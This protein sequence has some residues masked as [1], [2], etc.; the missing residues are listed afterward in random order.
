MINKLISITNQLLD[1]GKRNRLLNFKDTGLKTLKL[2]N[3]NTEEIFRG[4][5]NAKEFPVFNADKALMEFHKVNHIEETPINYSEELVYEVCAPLL[6][7]EILCYKKGYSLDKTLKSLCK[8]FKFSLQEKGINSLYLSF[9]FIKY[10]EEDIEFLAPLLLIPIELDNEGEGYTI[11]QYEDEVLLNPT[12]KFYFNATYQIDLVDYKEDALSTYY[13]KIREVLPLDITLEDTISIGIYSFY[14]MN[15]YNDLMQNKQIVIKNKNI[16]ALLGEAKPIKEKIINQATYP[17]VNCDS[18]QLEAI[19]FAVNGKSFCLQGPPGSGKSQTITNIISS[20]LGSGKKVL[21]VSEKIAALNVVYENLRRAN[22]SDFAIELHSNKANKKEFIDNLYQAAIQP[23]YDVDFKTRFLEAKY[24]SLKLNLDEYEKEIHAIIPELKISLLDLY[25]MYMNVSANPI[26]FE[27]HVKDYNF[28]DLEKIIKLLKKYVKLSETIGYDYKESSLYGLNQVSQSYALYHFE[29]DLEKSLKHLEEMIEVKDILNENINLRISTIE[30]CYDALPVLQC[31]LELKTFAPC[32]FDK[33][34]RSKLIN[35]IHAYLEASKSIHTPLFQ[36]YQQTII[37]ED[38]PNLI[39]VLNENNKGIFKNKLFKDAFTK[40]LSY[41]VEKEKVEN[42]IEELQQLA[43]VKKNIF[44]ATTLSGTISKLLGN[45]K[46]LNL[47]LIFLDLKKLNQCQDIEITSL[48]YEKIKSEFHTKTISK[49]I[50]EEA[51][52][53]SSLSNLFNDGFVNIY[54]LPIEEVYKTC[55]HIYE[56]RQKLATFTE[57]NDCIEELKKY[58]VIDYLDFYL[59]SKKDLDTL[60]IDYK[61]LFLKQKIK[62]R[63]KD[64]SVLN[65]F[66]SEKEE[67]IIQRFRELDEKRLNINRDYIISLNSQKRPKDEIIEGTEFKILAREHEK[68]RRQLPIRVLLEE[69]FELALD[70]KPVFLMSPLSVSTYLASKLNMFDCVIFDEASQIFASDALGAIYRAKQCIVIGD[71]KQMPPTNFF[72]AG[73]DDTNEVEYDLESILDKASYTF[74]TTSLKWHYRSRSEELITFSNLSF[75]NSNLIT[76][77]Q[78]KVHTN[79][80][81]IDF[82]Y[83][84]NGR[85]DTNTRTNVIEA[86][87]VCD[88]VFEHMET[89]KQSLGV[90]AFSNVQAELIA[91]LVEKRLKKNPEYQKYFDTFIDEPFFVKNLESVQ[92]DERDRIIFSICY[93]YNEENKFYQRFGPLNNIGGERRLN[94][95]ITRAKYNISVVSSIKYTDIKSTTESQGVLLLRSYL[96]FAENVIMN[97]NYNETDNG[98]IQSVKSYLEELGYSCYTH[99]GSSQFKV[100]LA[101]KK[102][103]TFIMAIMLDGNNKYISNITDKYRLEKLLLERLGWKYYKLFTTAWVNHLEEEKRRLYN[104]LMEENIVIDPSIKKEQSFLKVDNSIDSLDVY[105]E[106]YEELNIEK[107]KDYLKYK[108]FN[109][110]LHEIIRIEQPIHEDYLLKKLS[111][112][113]DKTKTLTALRDK[114]ENELS[115]EVIKKDKFYFYSTLNQI[116]LRISSD[117]EISFVPKEE[118]LH[119][120]YT[121]VSKNNGIKQDGCYKTIAQLLGY[122]KVTPNVRKALDD[123]LSQLIFEN[124]IKKV[125]DNLYKIKK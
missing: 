75:Y 11:R 89:S 99:Y 24:E 7:K 106:P 121:I 62:N 70:I 44:I 16:R 34:I 64:S 124:S 85:Y 2:L 42:I 14:K 92:G 63:M 76:I 51:N 67:D 48:G 101:V 31:I 58:G 72:H 123:G 13:S 97:K 39:K 80:F 79:G 93:G 71:N 102:E 119:G 40:V 20:L 88:M 104:A 60:A 94:V 120:L 12:L 90:V 26:E 74:D 21:F 19:Q 68:L 22:L 17:V 50:K 56:E 122:E 118:L 1:L 32:Y 35:T 112:I 87:K 59:S 53:L 43:L 66:N 27:V 105:F 108:D 18:S 5:K 113:Y 107:A 54:K 8:D 25:S 95:A 10:K 36:K 117:R 47:K 77:P 83:V 103:D 55:K 38:L 15:M 82:Y 84:E 116:K 91:S 98:I 69:I 81:G 57:L 73:V 23:R 9:G 78:S 30:E 28:Y 125:K 52:H 86:N 41:R 96:E 46:D 49:D 100:D 65:E 61:K 45:I 111:L 114:I 115:I 6:N 33:K 29:T 109:Y 4:I 37:Q 3:K 110:I